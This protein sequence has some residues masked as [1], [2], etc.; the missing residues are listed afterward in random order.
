MQFFP[1]H[2]TLTGYKTT[3]A[4][5]QHK[6]SSSFVDETKWSRLSLK[7][8]E[9]ASTLGVINPTPLA[10]RPAMGPV[11]AVLT[12]YCVHEDAWDPVA[13]WFSFHA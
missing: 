11:I 7:E 8:Y 9:I 4:R 2:V 5:F 1:H 10:P 12:T 13:L 6:L 3:S